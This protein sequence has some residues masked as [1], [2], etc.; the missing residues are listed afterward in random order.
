MPYPIPDNEPDRLEALRRYQLLDTDPEQAFDD[1]TALA[2]QICGVPIAL[3]TLVDERRQWFKSRKGF[4]ATE[5]P[6]E[7]SFCTHTIMDTKPLVVKDAQQDE[8]FRDNPIVTDEPGVRFYAGAP[9]ITSDGH[10]L[11]TICVADTQPRELSHSQVSALET[12]ARQAVSQM[13][14]RRMTRELARIVASM[15]TLHGLLPICAWC[16]KVRDD[17]GYWQSVEHYISASTGAKMTHCMCPSCYA[18]H[19][20]DE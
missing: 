10:A 2:S 19:A 11:G 15:E 12:L 3:M 17:E 1:I 6:R 13:E 20:N 4:S 8:R 5:T 7:I 9:L 14:L 18:K 16:K